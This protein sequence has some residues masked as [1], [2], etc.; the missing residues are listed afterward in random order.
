MQLG[1]TKNGR[2]AAG[3]RRQCAVWGASVRDDNLSRPA[4]DET[5]PRTR[6]WRRE[7]RQSGRVALA[8]S[9]YACRP[10]RRKLRRAGSAAT[11]GSW[12]GPGHHPPVI[13]RSPGSFS[14]SRSRTALIGTLLQDA[15]RA[16]QHEPVLAPLKSDGG[17]RVALAPG[18]SCMVRGRIGSSG[19][20][21]YIFLRPEMNASSLVAELLYAH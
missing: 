2:V 13:G 19:D 15:A 21:G 14:R 3:R 10:G 1:M 12:T 5:V 4:E 17:R 18:T 11:V 8:L 16:N 7:E 20:G 6:S 9:R